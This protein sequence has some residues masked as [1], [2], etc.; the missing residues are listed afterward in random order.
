MRT[1]RTTTG[2]SSSS[3]GTT[4]KMSSTTTTTSPPELLV[5]PGGL[6]VEVALHALHDVVVDHALVPQREELGVLGGEELAHH[7]LV[8]RRALLDGPVVAVVE[9]GQE[10]V[11]PE[12]QRAPQALGGLGMH[13]PL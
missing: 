9:P 3:A 5:E 13:R 1:G 10:A 6:E 2:S 8:G 12:A 7:A 4:P 11:A